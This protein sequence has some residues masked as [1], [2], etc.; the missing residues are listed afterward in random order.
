MNNQYLGIGCA[1][2][3][4]ASVMSGCG[5]VIPEMADDEYGMVTQYATDFLL[6]GNEESTRLVDT[7]AVTALVRAQ[8][9][10]DAEVQ[11][12]I[13]ANKA[14][15]EN[16]VEETEESDVPVNDATYVNGSEST[17]NQPVYTVEDLSTILGLDGIVVSYIGAEMTDSYAD[18]S[19]D[20]E[21]AP[22]ITATS[23]T[24]L[25]VAKFAL[26][27]VTDTDIEA[28]V[29]STNASFSLRANGTTGGNTLL[30]MLLSDFSTMDQMI[31]AGDSDTYVLIS[32]IDAATGSID[33][34]TL[35]VRYQGEAYEIQLQ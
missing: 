34:V 32:Q 6:D 17:Q 7:E 26:T 18:E 20:A 9:V 31:A 24:T 27:N 3:L 12:K 14:A 33:S 22:E 25:L 15:R 1:L 29:F 19:E 11:A 13:A 35:T 21:F 5:N 28:D 23:G 4:S 16:A 30:T 8:A 10:H 2:I